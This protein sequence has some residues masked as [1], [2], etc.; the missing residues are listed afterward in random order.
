MPD[1]ETSAGGIYG[2]I[3]RN[4]NEQQALPRDFHLPAESG[5][6]FFADGARDGVTYFHSDKTLADP[7]PVRAALMLMTQMMAAQTDLH[8]ALALAESLCSQHS[9]LLMRSEIHRIF[10]AYVERTGAKEDFLLPEQAAND[11]VCAARI[12]ALRVFGDLCTE[13]ESRETVKL[14]IMAYAALP[15]RCM[16]RKRLLTLAVCNEFTFY[17]AIALLRRVGGN[18]DLLRAAKRVTG[19]GRIHAVEALEPTSEQVQSWLL[20]EGCRNEIMPQYS[21]LT[22]Y[23][24]TQ[25]R[26]MLRQN[27]SDIQLEQIA[28]VLS[29]LLAERSMP[30]IRAVREADLMLLDFISQ[31]MQHTLTLGILELV[32]AVMHR[33]EHPELRECC[34]VLLHTPGAERVVRRAAAAGRAKALARYLNLE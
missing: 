15:P 27:I 31:A 33:R 8:K 29:A 34:A 24:K 22:V 6:L 9:V 4:M 18:D 32:F 26:R 7:K 28:Y 14:G 25:I 5:G 10:S 23:R 1:H 17:A 16:D 3:C 30:G 12:R 13:S 21:A 19:W 2:L 20:A 11:D